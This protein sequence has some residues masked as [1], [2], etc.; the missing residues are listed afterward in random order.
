MRTTA[1]HDIAH[2]GHVELL[3]SEFEK[4]HWFFTELLGMSEVAR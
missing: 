2:I 4:S 1:F 3:T